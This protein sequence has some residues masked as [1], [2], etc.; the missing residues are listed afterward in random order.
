MAFRRM[1]VFHGGHFQGN[2]HSATLC[3]YMDTCYSHIQGCIKFC[4]DWRRGVRADWCGCV[5]GMLGKAASI[6]AADWVP[7]IVCSRPL[8]GYVDFTNA[9]CLYKDLEYFPLFVTRR[10]G[11]FIA[12]K[13]CSCCKSVNGCALLLRFCSKVTITKYRKLKTNN[14]HGKCPDKRLIMKVTIFLKHSFIKIKKHW[15][16]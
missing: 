1:R 9:E 7:T 14:E 2:Q 12:Y 16:K 11:V 6:R 8:C 5:R 13:Y 4:E 10:L 15:Q 3:M